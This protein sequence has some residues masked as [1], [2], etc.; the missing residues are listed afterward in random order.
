MAESPPINPQDIAKLRRVREVLE[1]RKAQLQEELTDVNNALQ[2][3]NQPG[4]AR[5]IE[6]LTR[7]FK[8]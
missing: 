1:G 5:A 8:G 7:A 6:V 3:L 4:I 2:E